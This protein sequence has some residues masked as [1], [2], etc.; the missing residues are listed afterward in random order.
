MNFTFEGK[1]FMIISTAANN[2]GISKV[3]VDGKSYNADGYS[4]TL[5]NKALFAINNL[6]SGKHTV[7]VVVTSSKN[8]AAT[9][10]LTSI[11]A[12]KIYK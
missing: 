6:S 12:V 4:A 9:N 1:G 7:Q 3:I 8:A 5:A 10:N 11:D 2:R